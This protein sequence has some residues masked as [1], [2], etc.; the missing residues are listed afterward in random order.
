MIISVR[1]IQAILH[2]STDSKSSSCLVEGIEPE[3]DLRGRLKIRLERIHS[4]TWLGMHARIK[5]TVFFGEGVY[6]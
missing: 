5:S 6:F 4:H 1:S 3:H 2:G